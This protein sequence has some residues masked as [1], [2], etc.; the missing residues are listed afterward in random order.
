MRPE[1]TVS[2][3]VSP[4]RERVARGS[5][6]N[7]A[8]A[9]ASRVGRPTVKISGGPAWTI[10]EAGISIRS[11]DRSGSPTAERTLPLGRRAHSNGVRGGRVSDRIGFSRRRNDRGVGTLLTT[12]VALVL[13]ALATYGAVLVVWLGLAVGVQNAADLAAL[14]AASAVADGGEPCAAAADA[15]VRNGAEL[16]DCVVRGDSGAFVV[17]VSVSGGMHPVLPGLPTSMTR[18]AA[19]GTG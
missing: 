8:G 14:S 15:A 11:A 19:A 17:E 4:A 2:W 18:S 3:R 13:L 16:S 10:A 7:H 1:R 5:G 12:G 6:Q 9:V